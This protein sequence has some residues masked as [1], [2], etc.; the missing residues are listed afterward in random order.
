MKNEKT[1]RVKAFKSLG[2]F[3]TAQFS[4]GTLYSLLLES[5]LNVVSIH[6][7]FRK[8]LRLIRTHF[9]SVRNRRP[10]GQ[11]YLIHLNESLHG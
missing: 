4:F 8:Y 5:S 1:N 10:V 9:L 7:L 6:P 2:G 11:A 3:A